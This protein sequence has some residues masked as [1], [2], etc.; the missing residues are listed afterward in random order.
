M[1]I[2]DETIAAYVAHMAERAEVATALMRD[3]PH[4]IREMYFGN[5][6]ENIA[7]NFVGLDNIDIWL[8]T[9]N[10][11]SL[12]PEVRH[13]LCLGVGVLCSTCS[14]FGCGCLVFVCVCVY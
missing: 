4:A 8:G 10:E 6:V 14:V 11:V 13:V 7:N 12:L 2:S 3:V 5:Y 9:C 1:A